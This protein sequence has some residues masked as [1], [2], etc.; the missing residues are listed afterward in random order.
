MHQFQQL[1]TAVSL[2]SCYKG[3]QPLHLYLKKYFSLN[4]KHG[5][6]DRKNISQL[7]YGYFRLGKAFLNFSIEE[8]I[9]LGLF[10][11]TSEDKELLS[12]LK[13]EWSHI[14][15]LPLLKKLD[16][17]H[18]QEE[19]DNLFPFKKEL[20][21]SINVEEYVWSFFK[22]P[23]LFIRIRPG[24]QKKVIRKLISGNISFIQE[25]EN[26]LRLP[27][28]SKLENILKAG[29]EIIIQDFNSQKVGDFLYPLK[30]YQELQFAKVW[31]CCAASGG[32]SLMA[33][34]INSS[35]ELTVSDIRPSILKNLRQRF[36]LAGIKNYTSFVADLTVPH[37]CISNTGNN[38][39]KVKFN[40]IIADVPCTGSGTWGRS[41][42]NLYY[43]NMN[44]IKNYLD[45]QRKIIN[46][47]IPFISKGGYFLYI[48]CSVFRE[49]NEDQVKYIESTF[50][51]KVEKM[52]ILK[53][54]NINADTMFAALFIAG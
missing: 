53:G 11:S 52:E 51:F 16:A 10:L 21:Q 19:I 34:D 38:N 48:T 46:S 41:P 50:K 29:R 17:I 36:A 26:I 28:N 15:F 12:T 25:S 3:D 4:K 20:S 14:Y 43:F 33:Y 35:I 2:I 6:K 5:S 24:H 45:I 9:I 27:I 13:P 32:K 1:N 54:Y 22:Q 18:F 39:S 31:D 23:D 30:K 47:A 7:C 8:R 49:E 40:F 42:E 37:F 44:Q